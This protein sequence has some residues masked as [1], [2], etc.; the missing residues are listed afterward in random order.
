MLNKRI[1]YIKDNLHK[2]YKE[3][4]IFDGTL[5]EWQLLADREDALVKALEFVTSEYAS[6]IS[7]IQEEEFNV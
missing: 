5:Q 7:E 4:V 2:L 1:E 6:I 3:Q